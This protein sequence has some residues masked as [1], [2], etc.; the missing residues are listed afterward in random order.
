MFDRN[1]DG[2]RI[3]LMVV[4]DEFTREC[5]AIHVARRIRSRDAINVF[6][7]LMQSHGVPEYIRSDNGPEMIARNLRRWLPLGEWLLRVVQRQAQGRTAQRRI[8]L[9]TARSAGSHRAISTDR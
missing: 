2:R 9:H 8:V 1:D 5:L 7:G 4:I 6:A 3:K